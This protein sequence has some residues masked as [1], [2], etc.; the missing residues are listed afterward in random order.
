MEPTESYILSDKKKPPNRFIN[1]GVIVT[2]IK[3]KYNPIENYLLFWKENSTVPPQSKIVII[4]ENNYLH[5]FKV[6]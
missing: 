3:K 1:N 5:P 2:N 6:F 4:N